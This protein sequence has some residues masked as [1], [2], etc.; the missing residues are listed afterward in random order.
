MVQT[1]P[2]Q[3]RF[4]SHSF[5]DDLTPEE[6][7]EI[8]L[9]TIKIF[10]I[11]PEDPTYA[12]TRAYIETV[13]FPRGRME[14]YF[15]DGRILTIPISQFPFLQKLTL[16]QRR[17]CGFLAGDGIMWDDTTVVL[18]VSDLLGRDNTHGL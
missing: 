18:H 4:A 13:K 12:R 16:A 15:Q 6:R 14:V 17:R 9:S 7:Q 1:Q 11:R 8:D 5:E 10:P 3:E 2:I